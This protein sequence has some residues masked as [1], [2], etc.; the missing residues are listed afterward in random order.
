M[1]SQYV[2][3]SKYLN[4]YKEGEW[5]MGNPIDRPG[6]SSPKKVSMTE[7]QACGCKCKGRAPGCQYQPDAPSRCRAE[8]KS[9]KSGDSIGAVM[10]E[11]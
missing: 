6:A 8:T 4:H 7:S 5:N 1:R 10:L 11:Q 2:I 3:T 9:A